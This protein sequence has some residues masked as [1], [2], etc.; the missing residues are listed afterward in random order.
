MNCVHWESSVIGVFLFDATTC[1]STQYETYGHTIDLQG[2]WTGAFLLLT[3]STGTSNRDQ[4][5]PD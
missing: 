1:I 5:C 4:V 2:G 3:Y